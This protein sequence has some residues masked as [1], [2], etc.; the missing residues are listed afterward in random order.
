MI[1]ANDA[2]RASLDILYLKTCAKWYKISS[3]LIHAKSMFFKA[4][5]GAVLSFMF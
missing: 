2:C 3:H 1:N 5:P 4:V